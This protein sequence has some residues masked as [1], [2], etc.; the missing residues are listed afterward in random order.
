MSINSKNTFKSMTLN[1]EVSLW[2]RTKRIIWGTA[3]T[4]IWVLTPY[5]MYQAAAHDSIS[6][7]LAQAILERIWNGALNTGKDAWNVISVLWENFPALK[8]NILYE[9]LW[10]IDNPTFENPIIDSLWGK[11]EPSYNDLRAS[12]DSFRQASG[13]VER[14][15]WHAWDNMLNSSLETFS[16]MAW[17]FASSWVWRKVI[18][19]WALKDNPELW[20]RVRFRFFNM[21]RWKDS[22]RKINI[23]DTWW[24]KF[25]RS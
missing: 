16:A 20:Q 25:T 8:A 11:P 22:S 21:F 1:R 10:S 4:A 12:T 24:D 13:A 19:T 5:A 14:D 9:V 3:K 23:P 17:T 6:P 15:A 2:E 18:W 7:D